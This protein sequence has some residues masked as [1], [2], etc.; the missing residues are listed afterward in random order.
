M[1]YEEDREREHLDDEHWNWAELPKLI[2]QSTNKYKITENQLKI[3]KKHTKHTRRHKEIKIWYNRVWSKLVNF[4]KSE[5]REWSL[6]LGLHAQCNASVSGHWLWILSH[7]L[8]PR[9]QQHRWEKLVSPQMD[10]STATLT[11]L[12]GDANGS[13]KDAP[14]DLAHIFFLKICLSWAAFIFAL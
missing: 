10:Q 12:G 3:K 9:P 7:R 4:G 8:G 5:P 6:Q 1:Q 14:A 13:H 2:L 11:Y